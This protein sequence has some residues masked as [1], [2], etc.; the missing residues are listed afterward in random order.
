M[1]DFLV[2]WAE[3][4]II[5]L[6]IIVIIEMILPNSN[7]KCDQPLITAASVLSAFY[8]HNAFENCGYNLFLSIKVFCLRKILV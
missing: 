6:I 7:K 1:I 8:S 4:I 5:A 2:T 3:Q